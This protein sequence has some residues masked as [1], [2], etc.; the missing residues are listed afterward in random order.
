MFL[1]CSYISDPYSAISIQNWST[2][3]FRLT[4]ASFCSSVS[5]S[6]NSEMY[7]ATDTSGTIS[8]DRLVSASQS[9][10]NWP[11]PQSRSAR[12]RRRSKAQAVGT[13]TA[14]RDQTRKGMP[15]V[16]FD[17]TGFPSWDVKLGNRGISLT[18]LQPEFCL[19]FR[20][21]S[22]QDVGRASAKWDA[23]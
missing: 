11:D 4:R 1:G 22:S 6:A 12:A 2:S 5:G 16:T 18:P 7:P 10:P 3:L 13:L 8:A 17:V 19:A 9:L 14:F 15:R 23:S 20:Y 21:L